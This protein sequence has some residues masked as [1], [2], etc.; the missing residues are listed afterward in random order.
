M[1]DD[2]LNKLVEA[3]VNMELD[4]IVPLCHETLEKGISGED[5][6][7]NGLFKGMEEVN[8][9][10]A[11]GEYFVPE[12]VVC[13]DTMYVGLEVLK[14]HCKT[15]AKKVGKVV[16]GTVEGDTHDIGKNIVAMMLEA[17][18]FDIYD[19]GRNV[20]LTYFVDKT[21][22]V[23]ADVIALSS[24]LTTTMRGMKR[25]IEEVK[26]RSPER[27]RYVLIG[28]APVSADYAKLI[29]ADG[30]APNAYEAVHTVR[31]LLNL[32]AGGVD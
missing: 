30:Y 20:P 17:A 1:V 31:E 23:D 8:R 15:G 7:I 10:Y 13:A 21:L 24:L 14:P 2:Y 18:G 19:L 26:K 32:G 25:V 11:E 4:I 12:V 16:I 3:V 6:I 22:E 28:G 9:L 29:N 5:A 27:K